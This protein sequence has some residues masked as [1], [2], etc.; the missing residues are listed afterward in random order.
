MQPQLVQELTLLG[1]DCFSW[2]A[3]RLLGN[4]PQKKNHGSSDQIDATNAVA[5]SKERHMNAK[6]NYVEPCLDDL[7]AELTDAAY[8]VALHHGVA[9]AAV[10]LEL[11]LWHT[12]D[13]KVREW[14]QDLPPC[15]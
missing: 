7:A 9:G 1:Y 2:L 12:L 10:D 14:K 8:Q 4:F 13:D 11:D 6:S 3:F 5:V 15:R